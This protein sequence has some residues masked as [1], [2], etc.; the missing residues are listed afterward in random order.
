MRHEHITKGSQIRT[1]EGYLRINDRNAGG[2]FYCTEYIVNESGEYGPGEERNLTRQEL[3]RIA[4][5]ADGRN[6]SFMYDD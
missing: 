2:L 3:Q 6:H 1:Q 4:H 5:D